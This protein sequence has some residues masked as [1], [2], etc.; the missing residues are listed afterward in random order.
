MENTV[1]LKHKNTLEKDIQYAEWVKKIVE[2][3]SLE[4]A[5]TIAK[6]IYSSGYRDGVETGEFN[7]KHPW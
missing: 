5:I 4:E 2:Q 7:A 3:K 6:L 1:S